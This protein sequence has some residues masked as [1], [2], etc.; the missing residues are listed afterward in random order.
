MEKDKINNNR[1]L[2]C[3]T[4]KMIR[5]LLI[6]F[7]LLLFRQYFCTKN[8]IKSV[9]KVTFLHSLNYIAPSVRR[10]NRRGQIRLYE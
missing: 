4:F 5:I 7:K 6:I 10:L 2:M 8:W 3:R 1:E 9:E